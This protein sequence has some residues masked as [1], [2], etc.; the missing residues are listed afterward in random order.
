LER[1]KL[2]LMVQFEISIR[3]EV[4]GSARIQHSGC[5]I[6]SEGKINIWAFW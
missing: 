2:G 3:K 4:S 5:Y 6:M 1:K